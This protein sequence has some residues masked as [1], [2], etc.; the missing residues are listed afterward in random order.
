[1][2]AYFLP[3]YF[4][5]YKLQRTLAAVLTTSLHVNS[6]PVFSM[7]TT[8]SR[9]TPFDENRRSKKHVRAAN[10]HVDKSRTLLLYNS[11]SMCSQTNKQANK[12][13]NKQTNSKLTRLRR[14]RVTAWFISR[15]S[16]ADVG[17][18]EAGIFIMISMGF[19]SVTGSPCS[20]RS[21]LFMSCITS[22][23]PRH[24]CTVK[25]RGC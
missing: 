8:R 5:N 21:S 9:S 17:G 10:L 16:V 4:L 7:Q 14:C 22:N 23:P 19:S 24:V 1:M 13:T 6:S 25:S 15:M 20:L 2:E 18:L 12:Q 11:R 3:E